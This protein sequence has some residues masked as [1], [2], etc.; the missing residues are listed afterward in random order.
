MSQM[1]WKTTAPMSTLA[2]GAL[3]RALSNKPI[4]PASAFARQPLFNGRA[5]QLAQRIG[6][7]PPCAPRAALSDPPCGGDRLTVQAQVSLADLAQRPVHRL[8]HQV[9]VVVGRRFNSPEEWWGRFV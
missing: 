7:D 4:G 8:L 6:S 1:A 3:R 9:A 2:T 5:L